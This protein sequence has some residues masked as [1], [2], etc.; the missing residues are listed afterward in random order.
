MAPAEKFTASLPTTRA[1]KL[2]DA[3]LT[4]ASSICDGVAA[5]GVHLR[6]ELH[7]QDVVAEVDQAARGVPLRPRRSLAR[8]ISQSSAAGGT[9]PAGTRTSAL[10][11]GGL[12]T[13]RAVRQRFDHERRG[14]VASIAR[15]RPDADRVPRLE[16]AQLPAEPPAHRPVHVV[17][18]EGNL[19]R[20]PRGVDQQLAERVAQETSPTRSF[21]RNSVRSRSPSVLDG[22][23]GVERRQAA[24]AASAR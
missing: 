14:S 21:P 4:P 11:A 2:A 1:R 12:R 9:R 19:R 8:R 3:S 22:P 15:R 5:D 6:V 17:Y 10:P 16:R 24:P 20:D 18:G 7:R 13:E 23:G